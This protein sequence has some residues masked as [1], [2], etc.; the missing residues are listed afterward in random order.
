M[1]SRICISLAF[2]L[3]AGF[4]KVQA[5]TK[6]V[7]IKTKIYCSHCTQCETCGQRFD[8]ELYKLKGFKAFSIAGQTRSFNASASSS[9]LA[10]FGMR[11]G[12]AN[13]CK[14]SPCMR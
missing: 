1:I 7:E 14:G 5:Q 8:A 2:V 6:T 11:K 4:S 10:P 13:L 3:V 12:L 9:C